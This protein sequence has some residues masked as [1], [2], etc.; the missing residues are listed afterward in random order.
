MGITA[1]W[2]EPNTFERQSA[3]ISCERFLFP[4]TNERIAEHIQLV[5]SKFGISEKII[6]VVTDNASNF[7]K[8]F[9]EFGFTFSFDD[10]DHERNNT[11]EIEYTQIEIDL[12]L[13]I[14]CS[15]HTL[16]LVCVHDAAIAF[17][18]QA[19][20]KAHSSA[21]TKLNRLW[22]QSSRPKSSE[23]IMNELG[24]AINRP[25]VTRWNAVNDCINK[26]LRIDSAKLSNLMKRLELPQFSTNDLCFL[27]E[28]VR[29][30]G[31]IARALDC[32][33]A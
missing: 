15:C 14:R 19:Y 22:N 13:H 29:V 17:K 18:N 12:W 9:R 6:G 28:Y 26:I 33:Q 4:H 3:V 32:L 21:F 30:L 8:A 7:A 23:T 25:V 10:M 31:P 16:N 2:V 1:H 5:C 20:F 24:R 27:H 11:D